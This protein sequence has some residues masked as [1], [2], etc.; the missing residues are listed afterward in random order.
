MAT[1]RAIA[2][3]STAVKTLLESA[4]GAA[5]LGSLS[6]ELYQPTQLSQPMA[7]GVSL[8]LY[9]VGLNQN[10][11]SPPPRTGT[12]GR[13]FRP[14]LPVDIHYL[15]T[16]WGRTPERQQELL[17]WAMRTLE[18]MPTLPASV[19]NQGQAS[20]VFRTDEAVD[21]IAAPLTQQEMVSVWE[22]AKPQMQVSMTYVARA[23]QLDSEIEQ[24][25]PSLV[26]SRGAV[27]TRAG[28]R[29]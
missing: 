23:V 27:V 25:I 4:R 22:V 29:E 3:V 12:D 9:R 16:A 21:L 18:D 11:R 8:T 26:Q 13:R 17:G 20:P 28:E 5:G 1:W 7:E 24:V 6:V 15:L 10:Q 14:S 19:L 2:A